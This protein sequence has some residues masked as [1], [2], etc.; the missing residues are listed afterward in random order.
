MSELHAKYY[1]GHDGR[2]HKAKLTEEQK[3]DNWKYWFCF[4]VTCTVFAAVLTA[5]SGI[6]G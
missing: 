5:V 1:I 3:R 4:T 2:P 6:L